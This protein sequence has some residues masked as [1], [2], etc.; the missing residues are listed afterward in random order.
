LTEVWR[1]AANENLLPANY[2][3]LSVRS[4][5]N[6]PS[7]HSIH[8]LREFMISHGIT[9]ELRFG[10]LK[11]VP[12][13]MVAT[14]LNN[15]CL[16]VFRSNPEDSVLEGVL[17]STALPPWATLIEMEDRLLL[18]GG[19][20]SNLP[21]ETAI[22]L[23]ATEIVALDLSD[24][25]YTLTGPPFGPFLVKLIY[26]V[27][28]R[29]INLELAL[30]RSRGVPVFHLPLQGDHPVAIWEFHCAEELIEQGYEI[31]RREI[32]AYRPPRQPGMF[33]RLF[34]RRAEQSQK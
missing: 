2:L 18:D 12:L 27:Q 24:Q 19:A 30:A 1:S 21:I 29:Q 25:R 6:R 8:R 3:W 17:A 15:G 7:S 16:N 31:T 4:L 13:Y 14:D 23:G 26:S 10:D 33:E 34:G 28:Q 32:G 22:S 20:L 5:F 9:P 11:D